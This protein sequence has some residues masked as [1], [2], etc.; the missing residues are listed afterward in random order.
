M[1]ARRNSLVGHV[2]AYGVGLYFQRD[3]ALLEGE[4]AI[5]EYCI[6]DYEYVF[7]SLGVRVGYTHGGIVRS[8]LTRNSA[9][10]VFGIKVGDSVKSAESKLFDMKFVRGKEP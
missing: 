9:S 8:I 10:T 4:A 1:E 2:H 6:K 5:R 7:D 3:F